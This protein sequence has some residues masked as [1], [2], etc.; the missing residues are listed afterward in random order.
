MRVFLTSRS[1]GGGEYTPS[2]MTRT[3]AASG[4]CRAM[5]PVF[6]DV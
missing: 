6:R 4:K 1:R 2:T 3:I 5:R